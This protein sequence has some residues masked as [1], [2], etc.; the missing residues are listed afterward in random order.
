[1]LCAD[2]VLRGVGFES[3]QRLPEIENIIV[4]DTSGRLSSEKIQCLLQQVD[5]G[6]CLPFLRHSEAQRT[7][8]LAAKSPKDHLDHSRPKH[9]VRR[10][11]HSSSLHLGGICVDT[12]SCL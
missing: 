11:R 3:K 6:T 7:D 9:V 1:M 12:P 5:L 4:G 10:P 2:I 8:L